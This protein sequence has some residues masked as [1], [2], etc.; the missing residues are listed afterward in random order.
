MNRG[1]S[2]ARN[3]GIE[4]ALSISPKVDALFFL[5]A[6]NR[7]DRGALRKL[8]AA[9]QETG[10]DLAFPDLNLFGMASSVGTARFIG[11]AGQYS[12]LEHLLGN[13][14]DS[15]SMVRREVFESGIRFDGSMRLG[16]EDWDCWV[17]AAKRG[18]RATRVP[19]VGFRYRQRPESMIQNS[20]R[21]ASEL[22]LGLRR[23][24]AVWAH[25]RRLLRLEHREAPRF[26]IITPEVNNV[27]LATDPRDRARSITYAE[28][29]DRTKT[30]IINGSFRTVPAF[31][32]V[33][34][35]SLLTLLDSSRLLTGVFWHAQCASEASESP[36][37]IARAARDTPQA[38]TPRHSPRLMLIT[39]IENLLNPE[40]AKRGYARCDLVLPEIPS[41]H[42]LPEN[43]FLG[44]LGEELRVWLKQAAVPQSF[45]LWASGRRAS[46][47][48]PCIREFC[49][50]SP[51]L[52]LACKPPRI[53]V[54]T[55][56]ASNIPLGDV[57]EARQL[58]FSTHLFVCQHDLGVDLSPLSTT[59]DTILPLRQFD[60]RTSTRNVRHVDDQDW[61]SS[62][63]LLS[64]LA[65]MDI[66]IIHGLPMLLPDMATL[67]SLGCRVIYSVSDD[68]PLDE[69]KLVSDP[70]YCILAYE[71]TIDEVV[72]RSDRTRRRLIALGFPRDKLFSDLQTALRARHKWIDA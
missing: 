42:A 25:P 38:K 3:V 47:L 65:A 27:I 58:G 64:S 1:L 9:L 32:V 60:N 51:L 6:D 68:N 62:E 31:V 71:H 33:A 34:S 30:Q 29:V 56:S 40:V 21:N 45:R 10:V 5:D 22:L 26:A 11:M 4:I 48:S 39:S 20:R 52:P 7:L 37:I 16:L 46:S 54:V 24:H 41:H 49:G 43:D 12:V 66:V 72:S 8:Y 28:Y 35:S 50:L 59:F 23:K 17:E 67:C 13:V 69:W 19:H 2:T 15:A 53:G 70:L 44:R 55:S 61:Y 57:R 36:L 14:A 18:F 63:S